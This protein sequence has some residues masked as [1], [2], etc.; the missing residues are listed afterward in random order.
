MDWV[1]FTILIINSRIWNQAPTTG[2][3]G[4]LEELY[5]FGDILKSN[6]M[7]NGMVIEQSPNTII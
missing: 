3:F 6:T 5:D 4:P 7:H 1:V 2:D